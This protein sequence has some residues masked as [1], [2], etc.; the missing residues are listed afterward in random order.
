MRRIS[1]V[2]IAWGLLHVDLFFKMAIKKCIFDIKLAKWPFIGDCQRKNNTNRGSL[3]DGA[4]GVIEVNSRLLSKAFCDKASLESI[5]C[6]I[7]KIFYAE[8]PFGAHNILMSRSWN[9]I[10]SMIEVESSKFVIHGG[11][12]LRTFAAVLNPLGSRMVSRA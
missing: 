6:S 3:N 5:N 8:Y 9:E 1:F 10:P 7:G 4:K 12:P 2:A 11:N